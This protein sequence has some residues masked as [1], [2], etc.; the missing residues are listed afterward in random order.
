MVL[1]LIGATGLVG[2]EVLKC[3]PLH[4]ASGLSLDILPVASQESMG[5]SVSFLGK[6]YEICRIEDALR[7]KPGMA[8]FS[9]GH[10]LSRLWAPRFAKAGAV[11]VDNSSAWRMDKHVPL[12]I[13]EINAKS[14]RDHTLI[15]NPNCATIQLLMALYPLHMLWGLSKIIVSTYQS[16]SGAGA[17]AYAQWQAE[18][19]GKQ[20]KQSLP[21]KIHANVIPQIGTHL[22]NGY[23]DEEEK[24]IME[25]RKILDLPD[26]AAHATCVRVPVHRGHAISVYAQFKTNTNLKDARQTLMKAPGIV[27][28]EPYNCPIDVS[29]SDDVYVGRLRKIEQDN[30]ALALWVVADN[31]RK[32]AATN[33]I[34]CLKMIKKL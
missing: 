2:Q 4:M 3:L 25:S 6:S 34:Q 5:R 29:N 20:A 17:D 13:P 10:T 21:A 14:Y 31:L 28:N 33:A 19:A 8:I 30:K 22:D 15:A 24:I 18:L 1:A 16:V 9:A 11:V 23:M 32:G 12:L 26:L 27:V 7:Q